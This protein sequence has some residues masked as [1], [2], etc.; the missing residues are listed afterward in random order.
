M[1]KVGPSGR[2]TVSLNLSL[3]K[4]SRCGLL[5]DAIVVLASSQMPS[6][7]SSSMELRLNS[8]K[9]ALSSSDRSLWG[10]ISTAADGALIVE[11]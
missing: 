6:S 5:D 3:K 2:K 8:S 7:W 9:L 4:T 11:G 1:D 10:T